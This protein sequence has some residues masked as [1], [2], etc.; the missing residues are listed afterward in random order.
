[1]N[2]EQQLHVYPLNF[3]SKLD[4]EALSVTEIPPVNSPPTDTHPMNNGQ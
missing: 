2:L 4:R 1:M 3:S